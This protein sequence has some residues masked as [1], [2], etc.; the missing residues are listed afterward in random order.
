MDLGPSNARCNLSHYCPAFSLILCVLILVACGKSSEPEDIGAVLA[1][2][3]KWEMSSRGARPVLEGAAVKAGS[4]LRDMPVET[5]DFISVVLLN[6]KRIEANCDRDRDACRDGVSIPTG[7][8]ENSPEIRRMVTAAEAALLDRQP[9]IAR[10]FSPT[11]SRGESTA[12]QTEG[13]VKWAAAEKPIP[14]GFLLSALPSEGSSIDAI[15]LRKIEDPGKAFATVPV[16]GTA[17]ASAAVKLPEPGYYVGQVLRENDETALNAFLLAVPA[18]SY[19]RTK[20]LFEEARKV[21]FAWN[22]ESAEISRH[23][24]LRAYLLSVAVKK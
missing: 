4:S 18:E 8:V 3:G 11:I 15:E 10:S 1:I 12:A 19:D 13:V 23:R 9:D 5:G 17:P 24:F 22:G 21:A 6:G 16:D 14:L 2:K 20:S 7:Y